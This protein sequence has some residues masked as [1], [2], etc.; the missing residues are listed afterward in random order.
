MPESHVSLFIFFSSCTANQICGLCRA[1]LKR[2]SRLAMCCSLFLQRKELVL[3]Q[4][5]E[6]QDLKGL[7]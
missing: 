1:N 3:Q 5:E 6:T 7:N 4:A 2:G